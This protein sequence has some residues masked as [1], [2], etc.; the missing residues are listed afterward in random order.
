MRVDEYVDWT[1]LLERYRGA[2]ESLKALDAAVSSSSRWRAY[3]RRLEQS[4]EDPTAPLP[5]AFVLALAFDIR[6]IDELVEIVEHLP[7][8]VDAGT[9]DS[10]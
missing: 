5:E 2:L 3:E 1:P 4:L 7:K 6:E 10:S 9:L 8:P